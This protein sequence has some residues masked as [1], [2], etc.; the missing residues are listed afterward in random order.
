MYEQAFVGVELCVL[1]YKEIIFFFSAPP[2]TKLKSRYNPHTNFSECIYI[3]I[4]IYIYTLYIY[5]L[6]IYSLNIKLG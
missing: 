1:I 3:Y 2:R 6:Y 5:I 4:Y